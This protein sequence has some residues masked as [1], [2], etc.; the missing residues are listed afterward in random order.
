MKRISQL[1]FNLIAG[2]VRDP[3]IF[4]L[5]RELEWFEAGNERF[6]GLISLDV[7]DGDFTYVV[8][9]RDRLKRF[10]A[11]RF[12][13]SLPSRKKAREALK[14]EFAKC[15]RNRADSFYQGDEVGEPVDFFRPIVKTDKLNRVFRELSTRDVHPSSNLIQEMMYWYKDVDGNFIEQFQSTG[16]DA[17]LW[18]LYLYALFIELEYALDDSFQAPDFQCV[19]IQGK[20]FVE[21]TTVNPTDPPVNVAEMSE[22]E[23]YGNYVPIKF[24]SALFSKL[25]KKYWEQAHVQGM[26]L[27]FAIQDF[28]EFQSMSWSIYAL[29]DYLFGARNIQQTNEDGS[30]QII[31]EQITEF[32]HKEKVIS[33]GFFNL[34]DA[35]SVSAVIA[36]PGG[37][38]AKFDRMAYL[39]GFGKRRMSML[40][41]GWCYRDGSDALEMF[42]SDINDPTYSETWVEGLTV[43]HNPNALHPVLDDWLPGA[44]HYHLRNGEIVSYV[45]PFHPTGSVTINI[46]SR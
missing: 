9:A 4:L 31:T 2:Y 45:P 1:R 13:T 7:T 28:H 36:N 35:E 18:E 17:R 23:Y 30:V 11:V 46:V 38:I 21:A 40:R 3:V 8:L 12:G 34:P 41:Q 5:S 32:R 43:F 39:A 42:V 15:L 6:L 19:G 14:V 10:R 33:A 25:N 24:G 26:P 16:F 37:T 20:F 22:E 44:A 29:V 27:I